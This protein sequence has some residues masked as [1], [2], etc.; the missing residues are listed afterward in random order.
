M[1]DDLLGPSNQNK[2]PARKFAPKLKGKLEPKPA[3]PKLEP[4]P[5]RAVLKSE[6]AELNHALFPTKK[7]EDSKPEVAA[8]APETLSTAN[9]TA[10]MNI[11]NKGEMMEES[12]DGTTKME[13]EKEGETEESGEEDLM[14]VDDDEDRVV[15]EIDVYFNP[16]STDKIYV[17]QYPLRPCWRPYELDERCKEVRVRPTSAEVEVDLEPYMDSRNYDVNSPHAAKMTKQTLSSTWKPPRTTSN[18]VGVLMGNKLHL[19]PIHA[20]VQLRPSMEYLNPDGLKKDNDVTRDLGAKVKSE[21]SDGEKSAGPSKKQ[22]KVK[23]DSN[24]QNTLDAE[25][26]VALKYYD[27]KSETS[28]EY[29]QKM[30]AQESSP[31]QFSM[32]PSDY[33]NSLCPGASANIRSGGFSKRFLLSLPLEERLKKYLCKGDVLIHRFTSIKHLGPEISEDD[34]L[35]ILQTHARLVQGLWVPKSTLLIPE[36]EIERV[37]RDYVLF[38]F[39]E[40]LKVVPSQFEIPGKFGQALKKF[41]NL[42]GN[43]IHSSNEWKFKERRDESFIKLHHNTV[44]E[45]K[46]LWE[47]TGKKAGDYIQDKARARF[48]MKTMPKPSSADRPGPLRASDKSAQRPSTVAATGKM[49]MSNETRLALPK[50]L[51]KLFKEQSVYSFQAICQGLR[52]SAVSSSTHPKTDASMDIAAAYGVDAPQE[53]LKAVINETAINIH[54]SYVLRSGAE[55][56]EHT[57]LRKVVIDLLCAKGPGAKLSKADINAAAEIALGIKDITPIELKSAIGDICE[58]KGRSY[59]LKSSDGKP[60]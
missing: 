50:A 33:V 44:L 39:S 25:S 2:A 56:A 24:E 13:V 22:S 14:E 58:C 42:F 23:G 20:V 15:R 12:I 43:K 36:N 11:G 30:V 17:L 29:L 32:S 59:S 9:G 51:Q 3:K 16:S 34:L 53:E 31:I 7:E 37:S 1:D 10:K 48:G 41:V 28:A 6:P 5:E 54:G 21:V 38:L 35:R 47:N 57:A 52:D 27:S 8:M 18:A 55:K 40:N 60:K 4:K 26:W 19:N 49:K 46:K 45:Q